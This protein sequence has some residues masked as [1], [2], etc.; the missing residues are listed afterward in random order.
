MASSINASTSGGGGVIVTSDATGNLDIQS[1]ATTVVAVTS[2][3]V[4]VTGTLAATGAVSGTTGTFTGVS[5]FPAGTALLPAITTTGDT[6]TGVWFPAADTVAASTGGTERMRIDSSGNAMIGLTSINAGTGFTGQSK[7]LVAGSIIGNDGGFG[8]RGFAAA[9]AT[10]T[11]VVAN[12][13]SLRVTI[14]S[15]NSSV[16]ARIGAYIFVGLNKGA[17]SNPTVLTLA[18]TGTPQWTFSYALSGANDTTVTVTAGA[19]NQGTRIFIE[20]LGG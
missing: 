2:A 16:T 6:N 18:T 15:T 19:D 14:F 20:P 8:A 11:F 17:G 13:G 1:G 12:N 7:Q 10:A 9:S 5:T 4:A 3:G